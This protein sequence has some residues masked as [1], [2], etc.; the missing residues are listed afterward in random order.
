RSTSATLLP[1]FAAWIA[2]FCPAG[3]DP[4]TTRSNSVTVRVWQ[5]RKQCAN[6]VAHDARIRSAARLLHHLTDEEAEQPL[7]AAAVLLCLSGVR[8]D[9]SLDDR[10]ELG[11][12][13]D[14]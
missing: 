7:L 6:P 2:A 11:R 1:S 5:L 10:V 9:D 3:P 13:R 4:T 8:L 14:H 12:V